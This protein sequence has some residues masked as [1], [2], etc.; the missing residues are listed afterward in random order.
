MTITWP[1]ICEFLGFTCAAGTPVWLAPVGAAVGCALLAAL[2]TFALLRVLRLR[3]RK[4][5]T[6]PDPAPSTTAAAAVP[7]AAPAPELGVTSAAPA[8]QDEGTQ[9]WLEEQV[10]QARN[11]GEPHLYTRLQAAR[12]PR[13]LVRRWKHLNHVLG[14]ETADTYVASAA[15]GAVVFLALLIGLGWLGQSTI[16]AWGWAIGLA[17]GLCVGFAV[18]Y[19]R[20]IRLVYQETY[21]E[22]DANE[23]QSSI[24]A[25][26]DTT[27]IAVAFLPRLAFLL[28]PD[29]LE[30]NRGQTGFRDKGARIAKRLSFG[31]SVTDLRSDADYYALANDPSAL[32][33]APSIEFYS[34][35]TLV[36][37]CGRYMRLFAV[38]NAQSQRERMLNSL[39]KSIWPH[40]ALLGGMAGAVLIILG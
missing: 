21:I 8:G 17:V 11:Y 4:A 12:A 1:A 5:S 37:K 16:G 10:E 23:Y 32:I 19:S 14:A 18:G 6:P 27:D 25:N 22:V 24:S 26:S 40:L 15:P 29:A 31:Q 30:G 9:A 7:A 39:I 38:S 34:I 28:E 35:N 3:N 33:P 20:F 2:I 36:R 13:A